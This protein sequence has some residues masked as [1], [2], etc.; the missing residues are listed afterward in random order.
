MCL[1]SKY[2]SFHFLLNISCKDHTEAWKRLVFGKLPSTICL[3]LLRFSSSG[4]KFQRQVKYDETLQLCEIHIHDDSQSTEITRVS[5]KLVAVIVH[6]GSKLSSGHYVCYTKRSESWYCTDDARI[7]ECTAFEAINQ[8]AY[9]L[10][11]ERDVSDNPVVE[12][13]PG[14]KAFN[15]HTYIKNHSSTSTSQETVHIQ[16]ATPPSFYATEPWCDVRPPAVCRT[17]NDHAGLQYTPVCDSEQEQAELLATMRHTISH[18]PRTQGWEAEDLY[19]L[20]PGQKEE[21]SWLSNFL[22]NKIFLLIEEKATAEGNKVHTLNSDIFLRMATPSMETFQRYKFHQLYP[23]ILDSD[24]ILAPFNHGRHW[25]LVVLCLKERMSIYLD[26]LYNG[27]GAK[28]AF[29]RINNFLTC[30]ASI[31]AR[32]WNFHNWEYF[33]IP[34][35][36]IAQQVNSDDCGVFVAKWAQHVSLGL[37]LDFTQEQMSSFRYSLI[38][39]IVRDSLSLDIKVPTQTRILHTEEALQ[40]QHISLRQQEN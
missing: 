15:P 29:S 24:V 6:I 36:E 37:P 39:D 13:S 17:A 16:Q 40:Q 3:Q 2:Q 20:L 19:R 35:S 31:T 34:S 14:L 30:S 1:L 22:L 10:F 28:M 4:K 32:S 23:N 27:A 33:V 26:S 18:H 8:Q 38:L 11:Y 5:Y 21:G 7:K 9:L 25:C 12:M